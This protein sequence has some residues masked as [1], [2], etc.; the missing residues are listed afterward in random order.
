MYIHIFLKIII[1]IRFSVKILNLVQNA[2]YSCNCRSKENCS[3]Q[4]K[5]LTTKVVNQDFVKNPSMMLISSVIAQRIV[6]KVLS[7]TQLNFCKSCLPEIFYITNSFNDPNLL[8]NKKFE[9]VNA[10][11]H[12]SILLLKSFKRNWYSKRSD[13]MDWYLV[14]N[15]S[16][17]VFYVSVC[18]NIFCKIHIYLPFRNSIWFGL[19][20]I[21]H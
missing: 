12:Q 21:F 9:L 16:S 11:H 15:V 5:C 1:Q 13:T 6:K 2:Q 20:Y 19:Y 10:C 8:N 3:L 17:S 18:C 14:F 7:K 4:N